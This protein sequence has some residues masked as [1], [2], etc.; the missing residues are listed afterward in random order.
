MLGTKSWIDQ[1]WID[2]TWAN[3]ARPAIHRYG[4]VFVIVYVCIVRDVGS[5]S[6][7]RVTVGVLRMCT[8]CPGGR[9]YD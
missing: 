7:S 2:Q 4:R 3:R 1:G 6:I 9:V 5:V 8:V